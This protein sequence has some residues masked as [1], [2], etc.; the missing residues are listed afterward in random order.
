[1]RGRARSR[2]AKL[3]AMS[4]QIEGPVRVVAVE[5]DA[6]YRT[7]LEVLFRHTADFVLVGSYAAPAAALAALDAARDDAGP[8]WG[9]VLM[10]L[11]LPGMTGIECTRRIKAEHDDVRIVVLTVFE[12]R[13][14]IVEA[15]CAGADGYLLKRT[16][17]DEL[18][19]HLRFVM[20]GG[21]PLSAGVART[22]LDLVRH[23]NTA[24][25]V[26]AST[27]RLPVDLTPRERDVLH[28]L[29]QGMSYKAVAASLDVSIDTVRTHIRAV[30]RKLQVNSVA[31]AVGRALR[32]KLV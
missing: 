1:M 26:S 3:Q 2:I 10:D 12:D 30:Y 7:S 8:P 15:I 32:E 21:S 29:V 13:D 9:L 31:E 6:R 14:N 27:G 5:D 18:L 20:A 25:G 28:C 23:V 17:S 11:D 4:E 19:A 24:V 22:V 16:S